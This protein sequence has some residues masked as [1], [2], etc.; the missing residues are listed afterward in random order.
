[1]KTNPIEIPG[2]RLVALAERQLFGSKDNGGTWEKLGEALPIQAAGVIY[3]PRRR[4]FF[5]WRSS[6]KKVPDAIFRL[7][8]AE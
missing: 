2:G 4:A 7:N 1:M 5:V 8:W 3:N 6:D